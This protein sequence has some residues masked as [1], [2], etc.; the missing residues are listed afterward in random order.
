MNHFK[1]HELILKLRNN[2]DCG[3]RQHILE[4]KQKNKKANGAGRTKQ[5]QKGFIR[6]QNVNSSSEVLP[7]SE[8][9]AV[10]CLNTKFW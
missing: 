8:T 1:F 2:D 6:N 4:T 10:N 3:K 5:P 7:L 9:R